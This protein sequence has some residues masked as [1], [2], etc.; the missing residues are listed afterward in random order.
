MKTL[1][2]LK[3]TVKTGSKIVCLSHWMDAVR[4]DLPAK[5]GTVRVVTKAQGNGYF[6]EQDGKRLWGDYPKA[7]KDI[8]F[9]EGNTFT[10]QFG[11]KGAA[12]FKLEAA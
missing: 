1:T 12:T 3:R 7:A 4:K 10:I 11:D 9:G 6:Y 5:T 8:S 2:E